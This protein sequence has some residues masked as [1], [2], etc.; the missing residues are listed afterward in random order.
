VSDD[1]W[2]LFARYLV[3]ERGFGEPEAPAWVSFR[4]G[5]GAPLSYV[6]FE[7]Q[8][9]VLSAR[10]GVTVT[11]HMFR[12]AMAQALVDIAGLKVAQEMLGHA[13]V[14]TTAGTYAHVDEGAMVSA[15]ERVRDLFDLRAAS[16]PTGPVSAGGYV[17][18]YDETTLTELGLLADETRGGSVGS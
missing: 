1:F 17:F 8:L 18:P 2:P 16:D 4:R 13:H 7:S 5:H 3:E 15:V 9:R 14:S 11:A 12:H 10:V 6:A